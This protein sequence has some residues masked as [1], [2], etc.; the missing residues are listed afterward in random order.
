MFAWTPGKKDRSR[1][2]IATRYNDVPEGPHR[3]LWEELAF[4]CS[5]PA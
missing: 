1:A 4:W 5:T 2:P 3:Q